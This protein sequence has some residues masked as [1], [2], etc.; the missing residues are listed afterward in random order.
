MH[1]YSGS[2]INWTWYLEGTI[3]GN[4]FEISAHYRLHNHDHRGKQIALEQRPEY[5]GGFSIIES[6]DSKRIATFVILPETE[7][8][9]FLVSNPKYIFDYAEQSQFLAK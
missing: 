2:G 5:A 3:K 9:Q 1:I 6:K 4:T 7:N 8:V